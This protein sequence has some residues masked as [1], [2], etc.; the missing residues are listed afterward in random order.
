MPWKEA[1]FDVAFKSKLDKSSPFCRVFTFRY[2][3]SVE[4]LECM[5]SVFN[6]CKKLDIG[7]LHWSLNFIILPIGH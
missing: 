1:L 5:K 7:F 3:D 6:I 2:Y 4:T